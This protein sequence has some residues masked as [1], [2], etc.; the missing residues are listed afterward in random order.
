MTSGGRKISK[1]K[2]KEEPVNTVYLLIYVFEPTLDL[3]MRPT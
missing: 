2:K 3:G 1:T